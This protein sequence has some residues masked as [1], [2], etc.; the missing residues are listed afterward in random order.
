M[1]AL[2]TAVESFNAAFQYHEGDL[3][4][5]T[6]VD[7]DTIEA[8]AEIAQLRGRPDIAKALR[9]ELYH[10]TKPQDEEIGCMVKI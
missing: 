5:M 2:Q 1:S 7:P 3:Q 8:L 4:I 6:P 9:V 10:A